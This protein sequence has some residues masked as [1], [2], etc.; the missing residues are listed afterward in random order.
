MSKPLVFLQEEDT[1]VCLGQLY[2]LLEEA[3]LHFISLTNHTQGKRSSPGR[4]QIAAMDL[5][6]GCSIPL[7]VNYR[8]D[9]VIRKYIVVTRPVPQLAISKLRSHC[10]DWNIP[11]WSRRRS[12][13]RSG[14]RVVPRS[15]SRSRARPMPVPPVSISILTTTSTFTAGYHISNTTCRLHTMQRHPFKIEEAKCERTPIM[16]QEKLHTFKQLD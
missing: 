13:T 7:T 15:S 3:H 10:S 2:F 14:S 5:Q 1:Q 6:S 4:Y 9:S 11:L 16:M 12:W 8:D